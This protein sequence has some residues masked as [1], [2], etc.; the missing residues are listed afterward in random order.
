[1]KHYFDISTTDIITHGR[2]VTDVK[3]RIILYAIKPLVIAG[4]PKEATYKMFITLFR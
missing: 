2:N 3:F 4:W 1:M